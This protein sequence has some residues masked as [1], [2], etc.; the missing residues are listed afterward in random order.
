MHRD[1]GRWSSIW[2]G[3]CRPPLAAYP[4][5][6]LPVRTRDWRCGS[7]L[8]AYLA[9][10]RLGVTLPSLLPAMRWALTPP[11]HPYPNPANRTR[12][13]CFLWPFP[14][15]YDAQA[16][17]G[18]LPCGARTFLE[19]LAAPATIVLYQ[20]RK[21]SGRGLGGLPGMAHPGQPALRLLDKGQESRVRLSPLGQNLA[22]LLSGLRP[23]T[24]A[25]EGGSPK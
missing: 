1:Q 19:H 2:D 14:S 3:R 15:S 23:P 7:H 8:A 4:R 21:Y 5:L 12:A 9:L 16:L 13:V 17:P 18:S 11:F 25:L 22:V 6:P 10:L 24:Q 20:Y